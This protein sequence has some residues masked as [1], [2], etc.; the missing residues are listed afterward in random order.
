MSEQKNST[1]RRWTI[2]GGVFVIVLLCIACLA[3]VITQFREEITAYSWVQIANDGELTEDSEMVCDDSQAEQFS[4]M[5]LGRYG[6]DVELSIDAVE[7]DDDRIHMT[8]E[9]KMA[10]R[11]QTYEAYFYVQNGGTGFLGMLGCV[12]R[13][14]QVEPD[15]MPTT[16]LGG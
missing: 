3:F 14:E 12:E 2:L 6:E 16:Y 4:L 11:T 5:F 8:G 13:I 9:L 10:D 15:A 1:R 7:Q